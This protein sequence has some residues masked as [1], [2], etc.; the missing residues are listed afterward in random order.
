MKAVSLTPDLRSSVEALLS[1]QK[2]PGLM[3]ER[4][5][6]GPGCVSALEGG[7]G[8]APGLWQSGD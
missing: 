3:Q 5:A 1:V 8:Q 7:E 6:A 4:W 2:R